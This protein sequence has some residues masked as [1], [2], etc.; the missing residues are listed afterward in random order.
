M[1]PLRRELHNDLNERVES[2]IGQY[3]GFEYDCWFEDDLQFTIKI[4]DIFKDV[5]YELDGKYEDGLL[6]L[7]AYEDVYEGF[8]GETFWQ[9]LFFKA[10]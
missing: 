7:R 6:Y 10:R 1:I 2:Y 8:T 5:E 9:L 4:K 3:S